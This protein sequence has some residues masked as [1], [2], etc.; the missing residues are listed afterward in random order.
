M[1]HLPH[2][3]ADLERRQRG[4]NRPVVITNECGEDVYPAILTQSGRGP[5]IGGF[6][7]T[8]GSQR[9][10]EVG[11]AWQGRVWGRTNCTFN[12]AGTGPGGA[13]SGRACITGDCGGI[14]DC[15]GA[16]SKDSF[17]LLPIA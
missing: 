9:T 3:T 10:L 7:L 14:V 11:E 13:R 15:R 4:Q 1:N 8:P 6:S 12:S 16:A 2:R 17:A 5:G